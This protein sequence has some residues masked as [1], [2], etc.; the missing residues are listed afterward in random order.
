MTKKC[1][2]VSWDT[3]TPE[4]H[5]RRNT[6]ARAPHP[7][8]RIRVFKGAKLEL[9]GLVTENGGAQPAKRSGGDTPRPTAAVSNEDASERALPLA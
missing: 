5:D 3:R 2:L 6:R 4:T 9:T 1:P 8:E 7:P